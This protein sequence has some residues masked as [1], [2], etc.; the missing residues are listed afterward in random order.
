MLQVRSAGAVSLANAGIS[1]RNAAPCRDF[2]DDPE[3]CDYPKVN[4][5]ASSDKGSFPGRLFAAWCS[6]SFFLGWFEVKTITFGTVAIFGKL[7][8]GGDWNDRG[9]PDVRGELGRRARGAGGRRCILRRLLAWPLLAGSLA[10]LALLNQW[11]STLELLSQNLLT[12][13]CFNV[14]VSIEP[15]KLVGGRFRM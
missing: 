12:L 8:S 15:K 14:S 7:P 1:L 3:R 5:T 13:Q 11:V 9:R 10:N 2:G 4:S 6:S